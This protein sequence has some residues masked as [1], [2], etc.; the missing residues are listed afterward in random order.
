MKA[1]VKEIVNYHG[2]DYKDKLV[3]IH[4]VSADNVASLMKKIYSF[5]RS[6]RYDS[7]RRYEIVEEDIKE[8]YQYW[9]QNG[10]T[11]EDFYGSA[12]VD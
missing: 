8:K 3:E 2:T 11:I 9:K 1:T 5:E 12:T 6:S 10:M 7:A 4:A